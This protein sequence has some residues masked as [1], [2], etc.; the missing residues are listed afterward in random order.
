M[1]LLG[2]LGA[3]LFICFLMIVFRGAPFVPTRGKDIEELFELYQFKKGDV[4]IDLGSGDGR[5]LAAAA[6]RGIASVGYELNPFLVAY[7]RYKLRNYPGTDVR[8]Q[9]F[10]LSKMPRG[11]AVV[12]VFLAGPFMKKLDTKIQREA[13]RLGHDITLVSYGVKVPGK[14]PEMQRGGFIVYRYKH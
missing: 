7:S 5:V 1:S 3:L 9:D 10:W 6:T 4:L 13:V 8:L 2:A 11:T 12:F 14:P